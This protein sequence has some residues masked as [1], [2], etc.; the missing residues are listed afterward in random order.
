M[1]FCGNRLVNNNWFGFRIPLLS[2]GSGFLFLCVGG[3]I[4][5]ES[6]MSFEEAVE[7]EILPPFDYVSALYGADDS[8]RILKQRIDSKNSIAVSKKE[9][10]YRLY[11]EIKNKL[12]KS[13]ANLPDR[14]SV[15]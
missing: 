7:K 11:D 15:V 6:E 5:K 1:C 2:E 4:F 12:E 14:K 3:C 10:A 13:A 8:L 9:E